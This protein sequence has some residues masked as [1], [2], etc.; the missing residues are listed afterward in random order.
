M[1]RTRFTLALALSAA[2]LPGLAMA[3]DGGLYEQVTDPDAAF[4][5]VIA[6]PNSPVFVQST[7]FE[8]LANGISPYVVITEAGEVRVSAGSVETTVTVSPGSWQT[9]LV[10]PD[11]SGTLVQDKVQAS[12]AQADIA[13]YNLSDKP[14]VDLY[15]PAAKAVALAAVPAG[16]SAGVA[17]KAPL[18]LDFEVREGETVLASTA[19]VELKRRDG[20]T[21]VFRGTAGAY[22]L[23]VAPNSI[24]K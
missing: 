16:Q 12:P 17:L 2:V 13:L 18:T 5:R 14:T 19:G 8:G 10:A 4:V 3:Q 24:A 15:V 1:T 23:V 21:F 6:P 7:S 11:G 22:E 9:F 20:V